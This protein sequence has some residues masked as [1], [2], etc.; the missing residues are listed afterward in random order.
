[1]KK[2]Q[3][4]NT[5]D[6]PRRNGSA[7]NRRM[8]QI[9]TTF[10]HS[11]IQPYQNPQI[12]TTL[13]TG[14]FCSSHLSSQQTIIERYY[15]NR[16]FHTIISAHNSTIDS[17]SDTVLPDKTDLQYMKTTDLHP[18]TMEQVISLQK[19]SQED[20]DSFRPPKE[21]EIRCLI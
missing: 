19:K 6:T 15:S 8:R 5:S 1:M 9:S 21:G 10:I 2:Y 12:T 17:N 16:I 4:L 20:Q 18:T 14:T 11:P 13:P 7:K 3:H